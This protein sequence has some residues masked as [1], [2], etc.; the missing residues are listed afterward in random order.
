MKKGNPRQE[1][2]PMLFEP[3]MKAEKE[4]FEPSIGL[5]SL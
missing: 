4:G 2:A 5:Y 1:V 3:K